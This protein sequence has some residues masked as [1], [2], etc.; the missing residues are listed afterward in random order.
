MHA[1][2]SICLRVLL[3][4]GLL[5]PAVGWSDA[6]SWRQDHEQAIEAARKGDTAAAL[7]QLQNLIRNHP[8][9]ASLRH[10]YAVVAGWHGDDARVVQILNGEDPNTLKNYVLTQYA[11]S[12]RNAGEWDLAAQLYAQL[13]QRDGQTLTGLTGRLLSLADAG[14]SDEGLEL[15]RAFTEWP[16]ESSAEYARLQLACGYLQERARRFVD[17]LDCYNRGLRHHPDDADLR[18]RQA[19]AA[20]A[21]GAAT[22]A[23]AQLESSPTLFNDRERDRIAMDAAAMNIRWAGLRGVDEDAPR[24]DYALGQFDLLTLDIDDVAPTKQFDRFVALVMAYRM[25]EA[26]EALQGL[27]DRH[28]DLNRLPAYVLASAGRVYL[29]FEQPRT[30]IRCYRLALSRG[31]ATLSENARFGM[32]M[33][34][35]NALSDAGE[36][37]E[38]AALIDTLTAQETPWIRPNRKIWLENYRFAVASEAAAVADAYVENYGDS[39]AALDDMLNIA[40]ANGGLRLTRGSVLRWRGWYERSDHDLQQVEMSGD[41]LL[42]SAVDR[43]HLSMDTRRYEA[44]EAALGRARALHADEKSVVD[45]QERWHLHNRRELILRADAE[46]SSGG[47]QGSR[48]Y[49]VDG[50]LYSAPMDYRYRLFVHGFNRYADFAEGVG[51]DG[52][53]GAGVEFRGD[54][55]YLRGEINQGYE[56]LESTGIAL[57]ADWR[58]SDHW[59]VNAHGARHSADAPLRGL[60]VGISADELR[61]GVAYRWHESRAARLGIGGMRMGDGNQRRWLSGSLSQRLFNAPRHKLTGQLGIYASR[62]TERGA[63]YFNPRSDRE[64][65]GGLVHEWRI[66]R[67]Y[68]HH[69]TQRVGVTLGTYYQRDFG[70]H[71]LWRLSWEQEWHI[72][73]AAYLRYGVSFGR[74]AYDGDYERQTHYFIVFGARL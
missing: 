22:H 33:G 42:R 50:I 31:G 73:A 48:G 49:K 18:R 52:R 8:L 6:I 58:L 9:E 1:C 40:P 63:I 26:E 14:R 32:Q 35:F 24:Y 5:L 21:I 4:C 61:T 43:G 37:E 74:R 66:F 55:L 45:L 69:L 36:W 46:R 27:L 57:D 34:L 23:R 64:F 38:V 53:V 71:G 65:T 72:N 12:A 62:N 28:G 68:D 44:A 54:A 30:A 13:G 29:Y 47:V 41:Y 7:A 19:L 11:K 56:Q 39:L 70:S 25:H 3:L 51:R 16:P 2:T 59:S 67:D 15:L 10:D 20:S 60:R 17:A